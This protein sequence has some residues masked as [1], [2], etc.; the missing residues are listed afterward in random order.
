VQNVFVYYCD[1]DDTFFQFQP[2]YCRFRYK[3]EYEKFKLY[4]SLTTLFYALLLHIITTFRMLDA[5][6][7]F[8]LLWYYCTLTVRESILIVNGSR[9]A[10]FV[11]VL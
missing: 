2:I 6:F 9:Y 8:L 3:D 4:C 1:N 10:I 7:S 5:A 11:Y